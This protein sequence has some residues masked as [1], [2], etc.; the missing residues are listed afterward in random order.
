MVN[1]VFRKFFCNRS[2]SN[3]KLCIPL[4]LLPFSTYAQNWFRNDAVWHYTHINGYF[5]FLYDKDTIHSG[6]L[7]KQFVSH[8]NF[9][10]PIHLRD[11][12]GIQYAYTPFFNDTIYDFSKN[13]GDT[14]TFSNSLG[15]DKAVI[16]DTGTRLINSVSVKYQVVQYSDC[17]GSLFAGDT[18]VEYFGNIQYFI[19]PYYLRENSVSS[20]NPESGSFRCYEDSVIGSY[21]GYSLL[22][23]GLTDCEAILSLNENFFKPDVIVYPNPAY[24]S[25]TVQVDVRECGKISLCDIMGQLIDSQIVN[26]HDK[27]YNFNVSGFS[28]GIYTVLLQTQNCLISKKIALH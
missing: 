2:I 13:I 20:G 17:S 14:Y 25:F 9:I 1:Q 6:H 26:T 18:L 8:N 5:K 28:K 24:H 4:V 7:W 16:I 12:L 22:S 15:C 27:I 11:T 3:F 23:S 19:H 10:S 21:I